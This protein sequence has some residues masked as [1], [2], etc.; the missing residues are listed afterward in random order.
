LY[1]LTLDPNDRG[2]FRPPSLRNVGLT[3]PYMHDG[4]IAT[5]REVVQHYAAG[6]RVIESGPFAGDGRLSPL[7]PGLLRGFQAT[8][9]EIDDLVAFLESLS[10]I[11]FVENPAF[12]SPFGAGSP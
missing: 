2:R 6:G 5:L 10:D 3:A 11:T 1:N 8:E 4:S 7:K 9:A 12:A